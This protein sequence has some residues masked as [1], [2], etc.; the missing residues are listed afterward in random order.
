MPRYTPLDIFP[1]VWTNLNKTIHFTIITRKFVFVK[2]Q[3]L[4]AFFWKV[5]SLFRDNHSF[6]VLDGRLGLGRHPKRRSFRGFHQASGNPQTLDLRSRRRRTVGFKCSPQK[7]SGGHSQR[8]LFRAVSYHK[9]IHEVY[10]SPLLLYCLVVIALTPHQ[11]SIPE[12]RQNNKCRLLVKLA[13]PI[14][15][16]DA[17]NSYLFSIS[18]FCLKF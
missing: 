1:T 18:S 13:L 5:S 10:R 4:N 15:S 11:W 9:N 7:T 6:G 8:R 16:V 2:S 17:I 14:Y 3:F 12:A